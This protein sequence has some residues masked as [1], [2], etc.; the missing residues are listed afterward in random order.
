MM[1]G[2]RGVI[3]RDWTLEEMG[4]SFWMDYGITEAIAAAPPFAE[5]YPR[6]AEVLT[7]R[8]VLA[9]NAE[10]DQRMLR[11]TCER[12]GLPVIQAEWECVMELYAAAR[13]RWS[14][15]YGFV[16]CKLGEAC[17]REAV[18]VDGRHEAEADAQATRLLVLAVGGKLARVDS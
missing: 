17:G 2:K 3:G 6:L 8:L 13:H 5:V 14:K 15:R 7:G 10:F 9:Y 18:V 4:A 16:W 12:Y 1:K 11:Q